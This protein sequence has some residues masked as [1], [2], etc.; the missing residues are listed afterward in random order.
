MH[1]ATLTCVVVQDPF[2][3]VVHQAVDGEVARKCVGLPRAAPGR[4]CRLPPPAGLQAAV[5][6]VTA[7]AAGQEY[8]QMPREA[9]R[10]ALPQIDGCAATLPGIC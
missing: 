4:H 3:S 1:F 9:P 7:W 10:C 6:A 5:L 2:K 8:V